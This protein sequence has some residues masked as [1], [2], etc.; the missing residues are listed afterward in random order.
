M[1]S[2]SCRRAVLS[3]CKQNRPIKF[4]LA[5]EILTQYPTASAVLPSPQNQGP[6]PARLAGIEPSEKAGQMRQGP[7]VLPAVYRLCM[8]VRL[9]PYM[10]RRGEGVLLTWR[11]RPVAIRTTLRHIRQ[12]YDE[13]L[14]PALFLPSLKAPSFDLVF[15]ISIQPIRPRGWPIITLLLVFMVCG[16]CLSL[17]GCPA[18]LASDERIVIAEYVAPR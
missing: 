5:E 3:L 15:L 8:S 18:V 1:N 12:Q 4:D 17:A 11:E 2:R 9:P 14:I 16:L 10:T 6:E 7:P 13:E